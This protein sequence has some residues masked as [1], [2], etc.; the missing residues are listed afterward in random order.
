M[1]LCKLMDRPGFLVG[2]LLIVLV[3]GCNQGQRSLD[4][5]ENGSQPPMPKIAVGEFTEY[6]APGLPVNARQMLVDALKARL[7]EQGMLWTGDGH[8]RI[9][10]LGNLQA[11]EGRYATPPEENLVVDL[12]GELRDSGRLLVKSQS[13]RRIPPGSDWTIEITQMAEQMLDDL[14]SKIS[15]LPSNLGVSGTPTYYSYP[16]YGAGS[17]YPPNYPYDSYSP[18][19]VDQPYYYGYYGPSYLNT[20][21]LSYYW[22]GRHHH[23]NEREHGHDGDGHQGGPRPRPQPIPPGLSQPI[24]RTHPND[25]RPSEGTSNNRLGGESNAGSQ[26]VERP[27]QQ[28]QDSNPALE[29]QHPASRPNP[30]ILAIPRTSRPRDGGVLPIAPLDSNR[31]GNMRLSAPPRT[32]DSPRPNQPTFQPPS[33]VRPDSIDLPRRPTFNS[34]PSG[35]A[36][37]TAVPSFRPPPAQLPPAAPSTSRPSPQMRSGGGFGGMAPGS[38]RR[39]R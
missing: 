25:R 2:I 20:Y 19:Y 22:S 23:H 8:P 36:P 39:R 38:Q 3:T 17:Y 37:R 11:Y 6:P 26:D 5:Y 7:Q 4:A 10:L 31:G 27:P 29:T 32:I 12:S 24:P 13:N 30:A 35:I 15:A 34:P 9:D 14:R 21:W 18:Y 33:V 28:V 1:F 16:N